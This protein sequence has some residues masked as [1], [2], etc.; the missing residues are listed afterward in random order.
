MSVSVPEETWLCA[1]CIG[2][3]FLRKRIEAEGAR[4]ACHYCGDTHACFTLETVSDLTEKAVNEHFYRTS[5]EPSDLQYAMIR[6]GEY[7]WYRDGEEI[8]QVIEDLL[9]TRREIADDV[10]QLLEYRHS[11]FDAKVMGME[12]EFASQ[13]CYVERKKV[14]TG[15]LD[16]MWERFVISLKTESRFI[17][18]SVRETLDAIF[19]GVETLR[20]HRDEALLIKAGPGS[21]IPFLYRARWSRDHDELE[22]ILV[23]PDRELGPPPHRFSGANRMSARGISVFYG[24]SSVDTAISEIRP[25]VGC[26]VV[27][28]RFSI[29]RTLR[30]LNLPALES[31]LESGSLLD[32]DY[33]RRREQAAFLA[34]LI[35]RIV[36]P[37]LPGEEDFSYIPTQVIAE[38]LADSTR[39]DLDGILYPSVQLSGT[40]MEDSYN[41][42]LFHKASR[43]HLLSLPAAEDCM[44]RHGHLYSEDEWESDICVTE[45][46][47]S[48]G[49]YLPEINE[50]GIT[51]PAY[52][53][54]T[55]EHS[56][57]VDLPSVSVH[58]IRAARF[59]YSTDT[60]RRDRY[61]YT[62]QSARLTGSES[63]PW[64]LKPVQDDTPF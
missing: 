6:H 62:P 12:T 64:E 14:N 37:V 7:E 29:I 22:K 49:T 32:P 47:T 17:N 24:A 21:D 20:T 31:V 33:I 2:E 42:V 19:R 16:S 39:F 11:D 27:C 38:Y 25:P 9:L 59:E 26:Q 56:L 10:Q 61:S 44:I 55:R 1:N 45:I 30:L 60:V 43:V 5:D 53:Q 58:G 35:S 48:E 36:D 15:R 18:H 57:E 34:T 40:S 63:N 8:V 28:A 52:P 50:D 41:V 46:V 4:Q 51:L 13:S 54:D 23:T 3:T